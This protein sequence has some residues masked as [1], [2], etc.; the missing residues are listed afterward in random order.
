MAKLKGIGEEQ[1]KYNKEH[2]LPLDWRGS[3]EGY[4]EFITNKR[5]HSGSN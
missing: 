2:G 1:T 4:H 5:F 3:K